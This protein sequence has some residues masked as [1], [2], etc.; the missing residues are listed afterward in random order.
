ME[1]GGVNGERLGRDGS[2]AKPRHQ[3][4]LHTIAQPK[5]LHKPKQDQTPL[6]VFASLVSAGTL[7]ESPNAA[8]IIPRDLNIAL[9]AVRR[10]STPRLFGSLPPT[11]LQH[12]PPTPHTMQLSKSSCSRPFTTR[13]CK[14]ML[15]RAQQQHQQ[16]AVDSNSAP[17]VSRRQLLGAAGL[18]CAAAGMAGQ[19]LPA[20]AI[21]QTPDGFRSQVDR[22]VG[23]TGRQ[24]A[25]S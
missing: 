16:P 6:V 24:R 9:A 22:C 15:V 8:A 11:D 10:R 18:L 2:R 5:F 23:Q 12:N 14:N 4:P 21:V 25:R 3:M 19:P 7:F 20:V 17:Q 1:R 13:R